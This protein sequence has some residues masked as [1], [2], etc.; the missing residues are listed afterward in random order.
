MQVLHD[1]TGT[2]M[3]AGCTIAQLILEEIW[4]DDNMGLSK[5]IQK[6]VLFPV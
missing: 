6:F 1:K 3:M 2:K 5:H 4:Q